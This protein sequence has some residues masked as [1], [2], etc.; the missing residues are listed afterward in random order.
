MEVGRFYQRSGQW[1]AAT[2]RFRNVVD[3]YQTTSHTP[4]ALERLVECYLA[5]GI[6]DEAQK[7]GAV[8]G[9][10]YPETYWYRQSCGCC[11]RAEPRNRPLRRKP[12]GRTAGEPTGAAGQQLRRQPGSDPVR[13]RAGRLSRSATSRMLRQLVDPQRRAGRARSSS[14]SSPGS[15][16]SPARPA[17]ASRSCS[18]RS[19]SR[20]ARGP[21]RGWSA[22][23]RTSASVSAE[24][25]LAA[26]I[27][28]RVR[29][30]DEQGIEHGPGRAA[31]R[32]PRRSRATA[33][34]APSS[35]PRRPGRTAP[36]R[37]RARGRNPRPARRSRPAQPEGPSRAAR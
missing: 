29:L 13:G 18:T 9:R 4:E 5:L 3:N 25:D 15:A 36:R 37:R 2:Y 30:L 6:P 24:I 28:R 12:A 35:A 32:A 10:N 7:A 16:C 1:L 27:I 33:A 26:P 23:A 22:S 11:T 20:L 31:D 34:A 17:P 14:S 21:T 8:L 19:G